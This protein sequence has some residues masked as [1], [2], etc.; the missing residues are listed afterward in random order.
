ML[1][2]LSVVL[3]SLLLGT[4]AGGRVRT[5]ERLRLRWWPLALIGVAMQL[6]PASARDSGPA[7]LPTLVLIAS[8]PPLLAFAARNL[9]VPGFA[10]IL[11]GLALNFAVIA[12]N[13]GMPV[14]R[15]AIERAGGDAAVQM[16]EPEGAKHHLLD[17]GDVLTPLADV[18]PIGPLHEVVSVGDIAVYAGLAWMLIAAM[19]EPTPATD[20]LSPHPRGYR[21]KH[22]RY[23]RPPPGAPGP[24][25]PVAAGTSGS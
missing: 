20:R 25:P 6:V 15:E 9:R 3:L 8:F 10:F 11:A 24:L 22:R 19:R 2:P 18:I 21:G 14:S 16:A 13:G 23:R 4:L 12:P 7:A 5:L 1:L 17:D